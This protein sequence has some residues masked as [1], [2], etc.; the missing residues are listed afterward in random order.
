MDSWLYSRPYRS[1]LPGQVIL[2]AVVD[3]QAMLAQAAG[4]GPVVPGRGRGGEKVAFVAQVVQ[5]GLGPFPVDV[6]PEN[7]DEFLF[8]CHLRRLLFLNCGQVAAL[9]Q[10]IL[11]QKAALFT[12]FS[13]MDKKRAAG[14]KPA[15]LSGVLLVWFFG[16]RGAHPSAAGVV[17]QVLSS[18]TITP[19]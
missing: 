17:L 10:F 2:E 12:G 16:G 5:Q 4:V 15:A 8:G 11:A 18:R 3:V 9:E 1:V 6:F 19:S 13:T 14:T 7:L